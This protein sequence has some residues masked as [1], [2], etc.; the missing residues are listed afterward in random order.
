MLHELHI[1]K[2]NSKNLSVVGKARKCC[3]VLITNAKALQV[4]IL[5][6]IYIAFVPGE[7]LTKI[8]ITK[9]YMQS[10]LNYPR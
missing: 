7:Y 5:Y 10:T 1:L 8:F 9:I 4:Y 2:S 6:N 3:V